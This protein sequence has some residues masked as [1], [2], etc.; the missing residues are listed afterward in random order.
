MA[1]NL[2]VD[3]KSVSLLQITECVFVQWTFPWCLQQHEHLHHFQINF[4]EEI[5]TCSHTWYIWHLWFML[6]CLF[7][8]FKQHFVQSKL[9]HF[10]KINFLDTFITKKWIFFFASRMYT[11]SCK[12]WNVTYF[13][14]CWLNWMFLPSYH[15]DHGLS[16]HCL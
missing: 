12:N 10:P 9:F 6:N 2:K 7:S 14:C 13:S 15:C 5:L 1:V 11:C 3:N 4:P 8:V 16:I